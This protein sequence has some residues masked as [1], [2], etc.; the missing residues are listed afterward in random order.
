MNITKHFLVSSDIIKRVNNKIFI[1]ADLPIGHFLFGPYSY[2]EK[3]FYKLSYTIDGL[4]KNGF[5]KHI[6]FLCEKGKK[7]KRKI[8]KHKNKISIIYYL[9]F[10]HSQENVQF[11]LYIQQKLKDEIII[12]DID[13]TTY[14]LMNYFLSIFNKNFGNISYE[15]LR[16]KNQHPKSNKI[17][18]RI[19]TSSISR[20]HKSIYDKFINEN[21]KTTVGLTP[22]RTGIKKKSSRVQYPNII[23]D[24]TIKDI[25]NYAK[26]QSVSFSRVGIECVYCFDKNTGEIDLSSIT[27]NI[28]IIFD[29]LENNDYIRILDSLSDS[30]VICVFTY[31]YYFTKNILMPAGLENF[32][33]TSY[34]NKVSIYFTNLE[35]TTKAL[36]KYVNGTSRVVNCQ[37]PKIE[38]YKNAQI[39]LNPDYQQ[40]FS[41]I[42]TWTPHHLISQITTPLVNQ[43]STFLIYKDLFVKLTK[44]FQNILWIF[45][46]HPML[47]A[48]L[49]DDTFV[50]Y[51]S[52]LSN[53]F[54]N[55]HY[56]QNNSYIDIFS[57]SDAIITDMSSSFFDFFPTF[58]PILLC[59]STGEPAVE[60]KDIF[61]SAYQA[62]MEKDFYDFINDVIINNN[63]YMRPERVIQYN[64]HFPQ[65][66]YTSSTDLVFDIL[67][68]PND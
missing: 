47:E 39:F 28:I 37:F 15:L 19:L 25:Y 46:P 66:A 56:N 35:Q 62:N 54:N 32:L 48:V 16:A 3:G 61:N 26:K 13:F 68:C 2:V 5:D 22:A 12:S 18:V 11:T 7:I 9:F 4:S 57:I 45:R 33:A 1:P 50:D 65:H 34:S 58:K 10:S 30:S 51:I 49:P 24:D 59:K 31:G 42:I 21:I 29:L 63:D 36:R 52:N 40:T 17:Q 41:Y 53:N 8:V 67:T 43:F 20:F 6:A 64:R 60:F 27:E 23:H 38:D 14:T 44:E 55:F